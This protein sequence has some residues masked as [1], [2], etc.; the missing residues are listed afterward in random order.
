MY[1]RQAVFPAVSEKN[2]GIRFTV[3]LHQSEDMILDLI[4]SLS[5]NLEIALVEEEHTKAKLQKDFKNYFSSLQS[6]GNQVFSA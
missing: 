2:T 5:H 6:Y 1:K 4:K 3:N